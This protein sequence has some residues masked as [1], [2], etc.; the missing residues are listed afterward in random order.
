M[1]AFLLDNVN[2]HVGAKI[3]RARKYHAPAL[4]QEDLAA[5]MRIDRSTLSKWE[6]G[7]NVPSSE[8]ER[9][10]S[11]LNVPLG[12]LTDGEDTAPPRAETPVVT[13]ETGSTVRK[14]SL[15]GTPLLPIQLVGHAGAG[16][17]V[18]DVDPDSDHIFVPERLAQLGGLAWMVSGESMMPSLEPGDI[19][20]FREQREPR[21]GYSF[22]VRKEQE[23]L[24]KNVEWRGGEW[25]LQ[26]IN[27][28]FGDLSL[29]GAELIGILIG[30]YRA[31]G[32]RETLDS[33]PGGLKLERLEL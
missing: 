23:Y 22:L 8:L 25:V 2:M 3:R 16:L 24:V 7:G 17:G 13:Q 18:S 26:S 32:S 10:A 31:K 15:S 27:P 5:S 20:I 14:I 30:W 11:L 6:S 33:D 28:R 19:A 9:L 21:R 29:E 4:T 12:W 1:R